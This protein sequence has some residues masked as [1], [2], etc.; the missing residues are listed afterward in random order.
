[1]SAD[2]Q[3]RVGGGTIIGAA[4]RPTV[5]PPQAVSDRSIIESVAG[6]INDVT[7]ANTQQHDVKDHILWV[8]FE[9]AADLSDPCSG[10]DWDL[11][12]GVAPPLLLILGYSNGI[13]VWAVPA[14]GEAIEV[15]SWRHGNVKCLRILPTP[16]VADCEQSQ[17][18]EAIDQYA[19]KRPLI[20]ICDSATHQQHQHHM[21]G[22][23][24]GGYH[25]G[26]GGGGDGMGGLNGTQH[27]SMNLVSL[28]DGDQVKSIK[29]K[30]PII[31][32]LANRSSIVVTFL[33]KIA[34]FDARTL[35]D[36]L[37]VTTC[38]ASPG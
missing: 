7:L 30:T 14:N 20:A 31:D 21:G 32:I 33:E 24:G 37:T 25:G 27:C 2:S 29:F 3:K 5:V 38:F 36:R 6:F 18:G 13:Q 23:G 15:L 19:H 9:T 11:E 10:D 1:M 12:G 16:V 8:R 28:K 26:G 22:G 17:G 4:N 34:V 35:E